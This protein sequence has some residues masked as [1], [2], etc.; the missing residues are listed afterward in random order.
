MWAIR[1][2]RNYLLGPKP[3]TI[4]TDHA[5]LTGLRRI[6]DVHGR[7]GRWSLALQE[8]NYM[9]EYRA[10]DKNQ[11]DALSRIRHDVLDP[12]ASF[13]T[14]DPSTPPNGIPTHPPPLMSTPLQLYV[15]TRT[16]QHGED[17]D[18]DSDTEDEGVVDNEVDNED[19]EEEDN[20]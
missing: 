12:L 6:R 18:V 1:H 16:G 10:G 19:D 13:P 2:F 15:T 4:I 17:I 5:P 9:V 14:I 3:F 20:E 11:A 8:Y 7:I